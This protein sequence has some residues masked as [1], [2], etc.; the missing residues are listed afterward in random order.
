MSEYL[1]VVDLVPVDDEENDNDD[2]DD[3]DD[4]L[5]L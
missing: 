2:A 3:A 1:T 5:S 4:A